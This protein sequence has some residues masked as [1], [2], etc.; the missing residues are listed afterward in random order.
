MPRR[1]R[2][3]A[4]GFPLHI[5]QRGVNRAAT[6]IDPGDY[7]RYLH[8]LAEAFAE[9]HVALHAYVLMGNHVHLLATPS[10]PG[11]LS[12]AMG[13]LGRRYVLSF[14][15]RH[16]RTG[17]L[18][19]GRFR[20]CLVDSDR[21]ALAVCRYIELNPVRAALAARPE[22]YPWSSVHH[23]LGRRSDPLV[24]PHPSF[25]ALGTDPRQRI[26]TYRHL[27]VDSLPD[28]ELAAIREY[29]RQE[30]ALGSPRFQS[31]LEA[32]LGQVASTRPRGRPR[33]NATK[34]D[35]TG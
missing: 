31:M 9:H 11:A 15:Q 27:L 12:K 8:W 2:L 33:K 6:F 7:S 14:N 21:Y 3:E 17:T 19:E 34:K 35:S 4:S 30:R 32:S 16:E 10:R 1:P 13:Q 25:L 26:E 18:W 20:S 29:M 22:D 5:T 24:T 23:H 28:E